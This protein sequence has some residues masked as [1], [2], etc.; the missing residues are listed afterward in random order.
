MGMVLRRGILNCLLMMPARKG[1]IACVVALRREGAESRAGVGFG[2][3]SSSEVTGVRAE[4]RSLLLYVGLGVGVGETFLLNASVFL[5][6]V[7]SGW[8]A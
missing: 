8:A 3:G 2:R 1:I 7:W 4:C 5:V 6:G